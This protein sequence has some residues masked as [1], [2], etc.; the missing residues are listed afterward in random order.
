MNI[1]RSVGVSQHIDATLRY[2]F[3]LKLFLYRRIIIRMQKINT[4]AEEIT[5]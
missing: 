2:F 4:I 1:Y 5:S 3:A